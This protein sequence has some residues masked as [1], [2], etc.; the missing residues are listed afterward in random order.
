MRLLL[1]VVM[2]ALMSASLRAQVRIFSDVQDENGRNIITEEA[3]F[4]KYK[5]G[6]SCNTLLVY[7]EQ[8]INGDTL[9][10]WNIGFPLSLPSPC[11]VPKGTRILIKFDNGNIMERHLSYDVG[12]HNFHYHLV[13]TTVTYQFTPLY[14]LD[15]ADID[16]MSSHKIVKIRLEAPWNRYGHYDIELAPNSSIWTPSET[17]SALSEII[18]ARVKA[19]PHDTL[20]DNF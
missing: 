9:H 19:I 2:L 20:Y 1:S 7:T 14:G 16:Y 5:R 4:A 10:F 18:R 3:V 17:I 8:Y 11:S 6:V 13:Y 15:D 12:P